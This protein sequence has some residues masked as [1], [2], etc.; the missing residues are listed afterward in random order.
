MAPWHPSTYTRAQ[1]EERR[2]TALKMIQVGGYPN[3]QIADHFSV[4]IHT[5][6]TWKVRLKRQGG[7]EATPATGR[8]ARLTLE[9]QQMISTLLQ[10]GALAHGFP[11]PT[12]TTPRIRELIGQHLGV[13]YH[14]DHVRKVLHRLGFSPQRPGKKA[15]EQ[16]EQAVRTWVRTTRPEVEK[17]GRAGRH[18]RLSG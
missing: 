5:V 17:K 10:K 16:H 4:S 2:L 3:Q 14:V 12:W 15:L 11:D 7:L 8:P 9:Q 18:A 6:Y 1:L 13:W